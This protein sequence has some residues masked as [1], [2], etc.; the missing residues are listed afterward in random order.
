MPVTKTKAPHPGFQE[1]FVR[2]NVDVTFGGGVLGPQPLTSKVLTPFGWKPMSDIRKGDII[3]GLGGTLQTVTHWTP[4][5]EKECIRIILDDGSS[6]E[7]SLDHKWWVIKDGHE[8]TAI[9][10]EL[11]ESFQT[12]VKRQVNYE[13]YAV[14]HID[15]KNVP[16]RIREVREIG[17]REVACIGVSND[18]QLY[19]TDDYIVTKNCGKAQPLDALVLA[20][21]GWRRMGDLKKG[22]IICNISGTAQYVLQVYDKGERD[23]YKI[24][25]DFGEVEA[26]EEHLFVVWNRGRIETMTVGG[27]LKTDFTKI[28][29]RCPAPVFLE[30]SGQLPMDPYL[31]GRCLSKNYL[32]SNQLS[33]EMRRQMQMIGIT[34]KFFIP[35]QY[36][37]GTISQRKDLLRGYMDGK[38]KDFEPGCAMSR[39]ISVPKH[40]AKD[41]AD[42]VASLGGCP[43]LKGY[44]GKNVTMQIVMPNMDEYYSPNFSEKGICQAKVYR[45][46]RNIEF[47]RRT[48]TRCILV[49]SADHLYVTNDFITTHNTYAAILMVAEPSLDPRFRAVFTRRNLANLK[50][51]GGIVDDFMEAYGD[52]VSVKTS[53]NPRIQFPS[54]AFVDCNHIADETPDK[55]LER[56]KGWQY[57]CAYMDE[58]TSY[59]FTTF[60][61]LS[62]RIRGKASWTGK[63]RGTT[64][65]KRSHWTRKML[66]WYIGFD[67]FIMPERDGVVQYYYQMGKGVEDIVMGPSKEAVY[68]IC[69]ADIDKKLERLGGTEWDYRNMIKSFVF[70]AGKMSENKT[71][72]QNNP[73]YVGSVAAVGGAR[74]AQLIEGNFNVDEDDDEKQL[75]S[76][77]DAQAVFTNDEA[78]NGDH[79]ITVDLADVGTDNV[80]ALYWD[81]FHI[82]DAMILTSTTPRQN[83]ERIK[84]FASQHD[85]PDSRVI[86]DAIHASYMY[87]YMPEAIPFISSSSTIGVM[88]LQADRLK[89]ECY[90]RL[91]DVIKRGDFSCSERVAKMRYIHKGINQEYS[92]QTE[93]LEECAVVQMRETPTG[94]KKLL[95][96][97][98]M[99]KALGKGR[100]MDVLDPCAIRMMPVLNLRYGDELALTSLEHR[101]HQAQAQGT[102]DVFDSTFFC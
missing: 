75:I 99:N 60:S 50:A 1:K 97:K 76:S 46:I 51:G 18:D 83:Y 27:M 65:P 44:D 38:V 19:I 87:D 4:Y 24:S 64:N 39:T 35:E 70:Y 78:R 47:S 84:M 53:E 63:L 62:T 43:S 7:S 56:I 13:V 88:A 86:Y 79:W 28:S 68:Q 101:E 16:V 36:K 6:A 9:A 102:V 33:A 31:L 81:G 52:Y 12:A 29:V 23:V 67:G 40:L 20:P 61:L 90:L 72:I 96:K 30:G 73:N 26:C 59:E 37:M 10:F 66:D 82:E 5:G 94:K 25:F 54:G 91:I 71:S 42:V 89:D 49:S 11:L 17:R 22:D 32:K 74:S 93:F 3:D 92:F 14:R 48:E 34:D 41:I 80:L 57:D 69:K 21:G 98:E 55:L 2:S 45:Q 95:T 85:V 58:L 15:G 77:H 100:S 8:M